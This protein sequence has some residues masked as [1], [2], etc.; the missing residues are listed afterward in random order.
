MTAKQTIKVAGHLDWR[1]DEFPHIELILSECE[2]F[3]TVASASNWNDLRAVEQEIINNVFIDKLKES[4]FTFD[5][6]MKE[7]KLDCEIPPGYDLDNLSFDV[8][9]VRSIKTHKPSDV[10]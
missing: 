6:W 8:L 1:T 7:M 2:Q 10:K 3:N 4:S 9:C 5:R